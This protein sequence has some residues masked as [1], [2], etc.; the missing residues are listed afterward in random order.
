[1]SKYLCNNTVNGEVMRAQSAR[2]KLRRAY[3]LAHDSD[4]ASYVLA[5]FL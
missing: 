4:K 3:D 2:S 5:H 1:M